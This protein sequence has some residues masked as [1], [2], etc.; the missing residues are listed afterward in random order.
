[1]LVTGCKVWH[2]RDEGVFYP[3]HAWLRT[4][5]ALPDGAQA[6]PRRAPGARAQAGGRPAAARASDPMPAACSVPSVLGRARAPER[7][8]GAL[9]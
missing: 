8:A 1:M 6:R 2:L 7:T 3:K 9:A 5:A 4:V